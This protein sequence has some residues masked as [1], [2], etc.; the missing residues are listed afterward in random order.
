MMVVPK[1]QEELIMYLSAS[2]GTISAVLMIER[3]T[4]QTP[5]Y[6][7][8][9]G[10][11]HRG[12]HRPAHQAGDVTSRRGRTIAKIECHARGAQY[13]IPIVDICKRSGAKMILTS[14]EG[15]VFTYALR[16]QFT[17]SNNEAKYEALIAGLRIAADIKEVSKLRIKARQY[18]LWEGVL[19]RRSFLKPWL[20]CVGPLQ[21]D[22]VIREIHE[23]SCSMYA[24]PRSVVAKAMRLGTRKGQIFDS[25]YGLFHKVDRSEI[26]GNNYQWSGEEV[27]VRQ[28][29]MPFRSPRRNSLGQRNGASHAMDE[30]KIG[31]KWEGPYEV[32]EALGDGA[33]MLRS[34]DGAVLRGRGTSPISRNAISE[35]HHGRIRTTIRTRNK[36][37]HVFVLFCFFGHE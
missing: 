18:E 12:H 36:V 31:S 6:F 34:M 19:Y 13:Y 22:Y 20:R 25:R 33:Y 29:S 7:I 3:D 28:H 9:P 15:A 24:G 30:G 1:P 2:Y 14:P 17:A 16:F 27:R 37:F 8:L 21:A 10:A 35:Q 23:G 11:S 32:T 26:R 4:V 5:I